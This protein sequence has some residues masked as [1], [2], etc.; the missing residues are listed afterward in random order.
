MKTAFVTVFSLLLCL[1]SLTSNAQLIDLFEDFAGTPGG[2]ITYLGSSSR[3]TDNATNGTSPVV[4]TPPASMQVGDL[5]YVQSMVS[6]T[7]RTHAISADGGQTWNTPGPGLNNVFQIFWCRFNGT[8]STNPSVAISGASQAKSAVMHVFRPTD[9]SKN[10]AVDQG[11]NYNL[12][13][14]GST[15]TV[16]GVTNTHSSTVAVASWTFGSDAAIYAT[17]A[18]VGWNFAGSAQYRNSSTSGNSTAY[19]YKI[20]VFTGSTGNVSR[21]MTGA[22]PATNRTSIISFYE[23]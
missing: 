18:G 13:P 12:S 16:T 23:F 4:I 11:P 22:S 8:W 15:H 21:N 14:S 2:N 20:M 9:T 6:A 7:D 19:S 1:V 5:V 3:P 17:G 10:W